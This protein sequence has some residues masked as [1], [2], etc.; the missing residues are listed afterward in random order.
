MRHVNPI[1]DPSQIENRSRLRFALAVASQGAQ[2]S[3][4]A[5][6]VTQDG[7]AF[8]ASLAD[9]EDV[10]FIAHANGSIV[11]FRDA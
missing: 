3:R 5:W 11:P 9:P 2:H 6:V 7:S 10:A 8:P 4:D 1:T